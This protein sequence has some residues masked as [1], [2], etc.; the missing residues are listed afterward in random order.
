MMHCFGERPCGVIFLLVTFL[1]ERASFD[2]GAAIFGGKSHQAHHSHN[3]TRD[4]L[5]ATNLITMMTS[6]CCSLRPLLQRR[7]VAVALNTR[8]FSGGARGA[9]GHGWYHKYREGLG[10]RHL[11]GEYWDAPTLE[12]WEEWNDSIFAYG[13]QQVSLT[14]ELDGEVQHTL[15]VEV[16]SAVLPKTAE[17]F[18]RLLEDGAYDDSTVYRIEKGVGLCMG[19]VLGMNGKGGKCHES[20]ALIEGGS[21]METE[22]LVMAHVPGI[23]TMMSPGI[24]KVDSRFVICTHRAH[25]LDGKHVAFA[26]LSNEESLKL[27]QDWEETVFTK[28][29]RPTIEMKVVGGASE[30]TDTPATA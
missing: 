23:I 4:L 15:D 28:R 9:R 21:M 17:N 1:H 5:R 2:S 18:V 7:I 20:V 10:G 14:L 19:D 27:V 29:G 16:A 13:S 24:D 8:S 11:Q 25:Q 30:E 3:L 22:P 12:Q 26:R 6:A